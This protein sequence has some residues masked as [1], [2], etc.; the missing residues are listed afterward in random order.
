MRERVS[1]IQFRKNSHDGE[2]DC[3]GGQRNVVLVGCLE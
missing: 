3:D 2:G 1:S